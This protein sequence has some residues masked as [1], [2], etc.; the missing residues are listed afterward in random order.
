MDDFEDD[1]SKLSSIAS[2]PSSP[3]NILQ[4]LPKLENASDIP[5][6][7]L[8]CNLSQVLLSRSVSLVPTRTSQPKQEHL[9]TRSWVWEISWAFGKSSQY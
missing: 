2:Y 6:I 8:G 7:D 3:E 5:D 1:I 4:I 9:T